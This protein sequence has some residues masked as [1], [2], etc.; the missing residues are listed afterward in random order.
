MR[1][2]SLRNIRFISSVKEQK[3]F[4]LTRVID[5]TLKLFARCDRPGWVVRETKVSKIDMVLW[6]LGNESVVGGARQVNDP[7]VA[8]VR[9]RRAAVACHYVRVDIDRVNRI[10]NRDFVLV[11]DK[12]E[13]KGE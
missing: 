6:R 10:G 13:D 4:V 1:N 12:I 8:A 5:P 11:A 2:I 9:F 7:F 3:C